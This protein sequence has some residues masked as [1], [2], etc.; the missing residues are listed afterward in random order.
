MTK[1]VPGDGSLTTV[2]SGCQPDE[3]VVT[4]DW[5]AN[6]QN[7]YGNRAFSY[8]LGDTGERNNG[9]Q[10][11]AGR[12]YTLPGQTPLSTDPVTLAVTAVCLKVG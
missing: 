5:T 12:G 8:S 4:G 11:D 10:V 2:V 7:P 3:T 1:T 9:Y 6:G